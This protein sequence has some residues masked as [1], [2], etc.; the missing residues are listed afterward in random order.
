[1]KSHKVLHI[2]NHIHTHI[3]TPIEAAAMKGSFTPIGTVWGLVFSSSVPQGHFR[4]WTGRD[5]N[6]L[7]QPSQLQFQ[8]LMHCLYY[9][10][11]QLSQI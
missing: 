9:E 1:M 2:L 8:Y 4:M 7:H 6:P 5:R 10:G 11:G 3:Q